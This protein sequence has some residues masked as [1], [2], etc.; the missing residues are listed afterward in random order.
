M[1]SRRLFVG[2]FIAAVLAAGCGGASA[3]SGLPSPQ[4]TV[5]PA[6]SATG[7][8]TASP[9]PGAPATTP[10][11]PP[12][13]PSGFSSPTYGYA[14][15]L[16]A[17]WTAVK[18]A[19]SAWDGTGAPSHDD[20][21]TDLFAST[22]G[23][24]AWAY[25]GSTSASLTEFAAAQAA[26]DAAYH[27]CPASPETDESFEVGGEAARFTVKHCPA[28]GGI[29]VAMTAVIHEGAGYVFYFQHPPTAKAGEDDAAVF[30]ELL[31]GV[32]FR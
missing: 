2:G 11:K 32:S 17:N 28:T 7:S 10:P 14:I 20:A 3:P 16:P 21:Q 9:T 13:T 4:P 27:P 19:S 22:Q 12:G 31:A 30:K 23:T 29:L 26:A 5:A 24:I 6:P 1:D 25:A 15:S 8:P 18:P